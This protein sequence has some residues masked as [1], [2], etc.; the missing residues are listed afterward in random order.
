[1]KTLYTQQL[2]NL[3]TALKPYNHHR[4][5]I[6]LPLLC[7]LSHRVLFLSSLEEKRILVSLIM[8]FPR[9]TV[10]QFFEP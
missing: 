8:I 5:T 2:E 10:N 4:N 9:P 6:V 7:F 1:M 3:V